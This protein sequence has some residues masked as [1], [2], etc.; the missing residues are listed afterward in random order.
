MRFLMAACIAAWC[1]AA[2]P[3]FGQFTPSHPLPD[4]VPFNLDSGPWA[5]NAPGPAALYKEA[6]HVD[7]ASWMRLYFGAATQLAPGSALR[8]T[9]VLDGEVQVLDAAGLAMWS[10]TSAYFNGDTVIVEI[11][12]GPKTA[13]NRVVIEM[14]AHSEAPQQ[15]GNGGQ[16][17]IC[18]ASDDRVP[19]DELW[20]ARLFPAGCTATVYTQDSCMVSAGHC[21]GGSMVVQFNVPNSLGNC[22]P[23]SPPLADQFPITDVLFENNGPGNDWSV[24]LTGN[25]NQGQQPYERYGVLRPMAAAPAPDGA[26]VQL[27]GYGVDNTCVLSQTQQF[28]DGN[29]CDVTGSF[30]T[31]SVDL[32][33]GNS[34]SALLRNNEIIGIATHCPCC[35]IATRHDVA[36][37]TAARLDLCPQENQQTTTLPF[38]DDF[39]VVALDPELWTGVDGAEG[40]TRGIGEP[41]PT[42]SMNLDGTFPG[43][44]QA[45][46]AIMNTAGNP[47]LR[48]NYWFQQTGTDDPPETGEDLVIEY[49]NSSGSWIQLNRHFGADPDMTVYQFVTLP[50]PAGAQHAGFRLRFRAI[51]NAND[52]DDD[53]FVDDVCIGTLADCPLPTPTGACCLAGGTCQI[54]TS[55]NCSAAGGVYQG[56][57]TLCSPNP[58]TQPTGACCISDGSCQVLTSA[59]CGTAGGTYQGDDTSCSPNDCPQPCP[60]DLDSSGD[61]GVTDL[62]ELLAAWGTDPGGPPDFDGDGDVDIND[63]IA[64]LANWGPC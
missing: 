29:I 8:L 18:G 43:G 53:W 7:G 22:Q 47:N 63:L 44:D 4:P 41:S 38:F 40:S 15:V 28:D 3:A 20:T 61:V 50:L 6:V 9:S 24:M 14:L 42:L 21:I 31:F 1:G 58:C 39:P 2:V 19:S 35:N 17:G 55:A 16:C 34:G 27:Y 26:L 51:S 25:N 48:V 10:N 5:N 59:D 30:Y 11:V 52:S 46:T 13:G 37:F 54:Q 62:I 60:H 64:L 36:D 33:G 12:A 23:I 45:R 56:D 57:N 49:L 32:R